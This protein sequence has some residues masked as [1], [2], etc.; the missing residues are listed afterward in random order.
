MQSD[1]G[2]PGEMAATLFTAITLL[3]ACSPDRTVGAWQVVP[4]ETGFDVLREDGSA[5]V[6]GLGLEL[7]T[8]TASIE[9]QTGSYRFDD[10]TVEWTAVIPHGHPSGRDP[11]LTWELDDVDGN[12]LGQVSVAQLSAGILAIGVVAADSAVNRTRFSVP[13]TGDDHFAGFGQHAQDVDHVGQAFPLWVSEP[14]IGKSDTETQ[15]DDWFLTGTRHATSYPDPFFIRPD[16]L[17]VE[18]VTQA[19][20]EVDLCTSD[21][22]S[23]TT[24]DGVTEILLYDVASPLEAVQAHALRPGTPV[25]PPAWAYAPWNDAV[26]GAE[27]V[28]TVAS[29]LRES[30]ALSG[31]IWTEDWKGGEESAYGYH[32]LPNWEVDEALYPDAEGIAAELAAN[33]FQW[34]AYFQPFLVEGNPSWDEASDL[35]IKHEDGTPYTFTGMTFEP[36]SVLDLTRQDARDWAASKMQAAVDIGFTGW[37]ADY[38][39]WLPTDA[40]LADGDAL[41]DHNAYPLWWQDTNASVLNGDVSGQ[42]AGVMFTRSGWTG[43]PTRSPVA[44]AGDQRTSFDADDGLPTVLP[45]G[46]GAGIAGVPLFTHDIGGY[47]SI[48]NDPSTKELWW[49]WCTLGAMTPIMRTHHGAFAD[50]DW[51]FDSDAETLAFYARWSQ[52]H[53][54]LAP[55]LQGL[56]NVAQ[57]TGTPVVRAPFL[58]YPAESWGRMDAWLLG[59]LL[60][61][62]V[63]EE[64]ALARQVDL[65]SEA[66]WFDFWTGAAASSGEYAV[67]LDSIA[68]FAPSGAIV[69]MFTDP[70]DTLVDGPLSGVVTRDE[71]D[72]GRTVYIFGSGSSLSSSFTEAD[73]TRYTVSG[74]ASVAETTVDVTTGTA[75]VG[76]LDVTIEGPIARRYTLVVY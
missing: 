56:A 65:P 12:P 57:A 58:T 40:V 23:A 41:D 3:T 44:W 55:Y 16:P 48:G 15:G 62:P 26:G 18:L 28:R 21:T 70:A 17:G 68:V 74:A 13:C 11:A 50:D 31:V 39:E 38:A 22:W 19:R 32:L 60:V 8:G 64:G 37:M 6:S 73:G 4:T 27:R 29:E 2:I 49:R 52:I 54:R 47:Q 35:V 34:F 75:R 1:P 33:G 69:P 30:G 53:G 24:W 42:A 66:S 20:V 43:S 46:I 7:G 25:L 71:V 63:L 67:P 9:F 14:G 51:Q 10:E 36:T 59:D 76:G 61:A 5:L 72:T 45:M